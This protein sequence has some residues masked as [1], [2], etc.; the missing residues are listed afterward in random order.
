MSCPA[1]CVY[2]SYLQRHSKAPTFKH[3]KDL[4]RLVMWVKR[5]PQQI[6]YKPLKA[7]N[8]AGC[9]DGQL[10]SVQAILRDL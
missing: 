7:P 2:V 10:C 4:N 1:I 8:E 9:G 3:I 6:I 5:T